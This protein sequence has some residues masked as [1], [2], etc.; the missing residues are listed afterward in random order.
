LIEN[1]R[2]LTLSEGITEVIAVTEVRD[3]GRMLLTNGHPMSSTDLLS[4]RYMRALAHIPLLSIENP[5][6]VLVMCF[7]V[8]NT[9]HA[10][11]LHPSVRRVEVVDLSRHVLEHAGYF[12]DVNKDVLKDRRV[13]VYVNDGRQHLQI[14]RATSYDLITLE[15]PPITQAGMG[16]LYSREFYARARARLTPKGYVSQWLPVARVPEATTLAMIRAFVDVFPNAVLVS[17]AHTNLLLIG[18]N[19]SSIEIDPARLAAA[20]SSAPAVQADLQRVDLGTVREIVGTFVGSAQTLAVASRDSAPVTDD[21]PI[22]EYG[23][24]SLLVFDDRPPASMV[25][26]KQVAAWCP[27][28]FADGKPVPLVD[29]LDT[30]LA[31]LDLVYGASGPKTAGASVRLQPDTTKNTPAG[32]R[33]IAGSAYLG[34]IIPESA[35]LHNVLGTA[36]AARGNAGEAIAEFREA[37]RLEPDSVTAHWN[38]GRSLASP[39]EALGHLRR[40]VQLDPGNGQARYHL[41]TTLFES[42]QYEDAV[43]EF[44]AALQLMPNSVEARNNLGVTLASQGKL[45]EAI[46]QF[47]QALAL[48]P[49]YADARRNLTM[50]LQQQGRQQEGRGAARGV[51]AP[52]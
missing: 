48:Q 3:Q 36:Y 15:P 32:P 9:A 18:A 25:D 40:A 26:V 51:G 42:R 11:T 22:Q 34:A 16:A 38:L 37:L 50:A 45:D 20:L 33:V 43:D 46:D 47:Q 5:E 4:Q 35:D 29:G 7:G 2:L 19:G 6:T 27:T 1:E 13:A 14:E 44:R 23:V 8:G 30:Y 10:A 49:E 31:L 28:C 24:R 41:A 21:R 52:P 12:T 17:G 39:E